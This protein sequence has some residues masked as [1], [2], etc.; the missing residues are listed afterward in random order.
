MTRQRSVWRRQAVATALFCVT[1]FIVAPTS[2]AQ[3][4]GP[5][6]AGGNVIT[7]EN[8]KPGN[9]RSEWDIDPQGT[10]VEGYGSQMSVNVGQGIDFKIRS[11]AT[12]L[13]VDVYRMGYYQGNGAR[14]VA[15]VAANTTV[16]RNQPSCPENTTTGMVSCNWG[17]VANWTVPA[18]AVSGIYFA[19]V[20]RTDNGTNDDTHIVFVVRDDAH[21]SDLLF[22]TS[23]TTWQA[24]NSWGDV[25]ATENN[26][27]KVLNSFYRGDSAAAPGRAVKLSYDRPFNTRRTTPW[28]RDFVWANEYP[29]VRFLEANG[30]DVSYI[31]TADA[32]RAPQGLLNHKVLLSVGHDEYWSQEERAAFET[33]RDQGVHLAFFSGNEVY[34]KTRWEDGHR[35]LVTYKE[36]LSHAKIDPAPNTWTGTWRDPRFSPPAD[37]GRPENGL[38]GTLFTVNCTKKD[39]GCQAI[40]LTVPAADGKMRFWRGTPLASQANGASTTIPGIVGYEWDEDIDNGHRPAGLV[41][42]SKTTATVDERL[43][44]FGSKVAVEEATHKMTMYRAASGALVFGAGTVQWSWGLDDSHDGITGFADNR[45]KQAT[46]NLFADMDAQP[47]SL[48]SGLSAASK[49]TDTVAPTV[50]ISAPANGATV[51]NGA[52]VTIS[53]TANDTGGQVGA[54]EVSTDGGTTWHPA[55]GRGTWSYSWNVTGV[56]TVS[57]KARAADDS[58]NIGAVASRNVVV[59]CPCSL[60]PTSAVPAN[61]AENDGTALELGVRFRSTVSGYVTGVKFYKGTGNTGTHTGS[62][63]STSGQRLATGTFTNES[64]TGWQTLM[65]DAPVHITADTDYIASYHAPNGRYAA[66]ANYFRFASTVRPPLVAPQTADGAANGVYRIGAGFPTLTYNGGNYY[67]DVVFEVNDTFPPAAVSATP[68]PGSSSVPV[69]TQPQVTF[70]EPVQTGSAAFTLT[71]PDDNS[72]AGTA[73]LNAARTTLTFAPTAPLAPGQR[74]TASVSGAKDDAGN[75]LAQPY[76]FSFTTAKATTPG[77]C[78]CSVWPD[79]AAPATPSVNDPNAVELG[80][81]FQADADGF[82]EGIRFYKGLTNTGTHTGTLWSASG[83]ELAT[84][85]FTDE[86]STGWQE[87]LFS[88][89]VPVTKNTTYVASYHAPN[90]NYAATGGGLSAQV[91]A[92]PLRALASGQ[93]GGNGVYRYGTH[94][95]PTGTWGA[96]NYWVDVVYSK[97]PDTTPPTVAAA[98]PAAGTTGVP[99]GA[100]ISV[101]FSEPVE[102]GT[103]QIAVTGPGDTAVQGSASLNAARTQLTFTPNA[104]LAQSTQY[105]VAVSGAKDEA[106]NTMAATSWS[107]TTGGAASCPCTIFAST[108]TP[109]NPSVN[110]PGAVELG[111]KFTADMDGQITGIRFYKGAG[112]TGTHTGNLWTAGGTLLATGTFTNETAS[113][114]QTLTFATPVAINAGSVYVASYH[115]PNGRYAGDG[116]FFNSGPLDNAPLHALANGGPAGGNGVY[117]YGASS[118]FPTSTYNGA[119]YWVDVLFT[120]A[121]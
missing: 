25:Q 85:T 26:P 19:H 118:G 69:T 106:G 60:F 41:T 21:Q 96:T 13:R 14:K 40:G 6:D 66:D 111:V 108:A 74:F 16:S 7:C 115:A 76:T 91:S 50:T 17:T 80:V 112:N 117:R 4:I 1:A 109:N 56:G 101:T 95:F 93:S 32:A 58:G 27:N 42:L 87:A 82:I 2:P 67:V 110:D 100:A 11:A 44:D 92:P 5:C 52:T 9:P 79:S 70:N 88:Q 23:D 57:I 98:S 28:G 121:S 37:G 45:I 83:Q 107:F 68:Y 51:N 61:P 47:K 102:E 34:W 105:T 30:Y 55:T 39:D 35:T 59:E 18:D 29:M 54:V 99:T 10:T 116:A 104:A 33:A 36:T 15:T 71:D 43:I 73:T 64:A 84:V 77:V 22:K 31:A 81:K 12:A 90:G 38:T 65:F 8:S 3:A 48:V 53:G 114:W 49:S 89:P 97:V 72:V 75:T 62:L 94:G 103:P 63:W 78:P 24:Y 86:S 46:V 113:G 120:P 20:V 119:N